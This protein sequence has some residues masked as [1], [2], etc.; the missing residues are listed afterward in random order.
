VPDNVAINTSLDPTAPKVAGD[1]VTYSGEAAQVQIIQLG[2]VLGV[3]GSR[4]VT[5]HDL[6]SIY[7]SL[8]ETPPATDT[9]SSGFNGRLQRIAQRI[10]SLIALLPASLGQ[11]TMA[12]SLAVTL[13]SDQTTLVAE[14]AR[15]SALTTRS[16]VSVTTTADTLLASNASR[17]SALFK[18]LGPFPVYIGSATVTAANGMLLSSGDGFEDDR[19]TIL[20]QAIA[21]GGTSTVAVLEV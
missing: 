9:A 18:N 3:E 5:R 14:S 6:S 11:K 1:E 4:T 12:N 20:W 2:S 17:K 7:G 21:V 16:Q 13:A 10:T 15:A 8:T 19:T